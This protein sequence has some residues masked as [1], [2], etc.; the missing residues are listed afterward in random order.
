M[1][2]NCT[3]KVS[4]SPWGPFHLLPVF[5]VNWLVIS[6]LHFPT[7]LWPW[8]F[9][10]VFFYRLIRVLDRTGMIIQ[11]LCKCINFSVHMCMLQYNITNISYSIACLL[12]QLLVISDLESEVSQCRWRLRSLSLFTFVICVLLEALATDS[13]VINILSYV[14]FYA[15]VLFQ[16]IANCPAQLLMTLPQFRWTGGSHLCPCVQKVTQ[17]N[18][19]TSRPPWPRIPGSPLWPGFKASPPRQ[20]GG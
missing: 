6:F 10:L 4:E 13:K 17:G 7:G 15:L 14:S 18:L 5:S 8:C 16:W 3:M 9:F 1:G 11:N 19:T 20:G 2:K 12:S